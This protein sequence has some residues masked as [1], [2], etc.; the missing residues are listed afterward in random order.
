M[1]RCFFFLVTSVLGLIAAF[2]WDWE[3]RSGV[4]GVSSVSGVSM[5][6]SWGRGK[7]ARAGTIELLSSLLR[8]LDTLQTP[9]LFCCP[10]QAGP[11][12]SGFLS[13]TASIPVGLVLGSSQ[14]DSDELGVR[15]GFF[16]R[17]WGSRG[18]LDG[19][20][21][22]GCA[23]SISIF[24]FLGRSNSGA[25]EEG[26]GW[27]DGCLACHSRWRWRC[28]RSCRPM[29]WDS[30]Y[31]GWTSHWCALVIAYEGCCWEC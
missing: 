12:G 29:D 8:H 22:V 3:V 21:F 20:S 15:L 14:V 27:E 19:C 31:V 2:L 5:G 28:Q 4:S 30:A 25:A 11:G 17:A 16:E 23:V 7:L 9:P 1:R 6:R 24:I 18:R 13:I 10:E 26:W